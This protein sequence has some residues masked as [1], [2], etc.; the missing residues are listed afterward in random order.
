MRENY[1]F[2]CEEVEVMLQFWDGVLE[3]IAIGMPSRMV[4]EARVSSMFD[5]TEE[6][7]Y[8]ISRVLDLIKELLERLKVKQVEYEREIIQRWVF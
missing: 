7:T 1:W 4:L 2:R 5:E 6:E 8:M 3:Y